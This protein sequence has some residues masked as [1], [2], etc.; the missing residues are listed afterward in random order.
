MRLG[1]NREA[2][3]WSSVNDRSRQQRLQL[4]GKIA[5][6]ETLE[7]DAQVWP[8]VNEPAQARKRPAHVT[9]G[10]SEV[11]FH[12]RRIA[13]QSQRIAD[14]VSWFQRADAL[15][16]L[17]DL[18]AAVDCDAERRYRQTLTYDPLAGFRG[19]PLAHERQCKELARPKRTKAG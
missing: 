11:H 3:E 13:T 8:F 18:G 6:H 2:D 1:R 15:A 19:L 9:R 10:L 14:D 12:R 16:I 7:C 17:A 4:A 5:V